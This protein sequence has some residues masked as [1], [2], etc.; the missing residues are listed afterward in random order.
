MHVSIK[1]HFKNWCEGKC[2]Q[3]ENKSAP[4]HVRLQTTAKLA[5]K[6]FTRCARQASM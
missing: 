4:A 3:V 5:K 1:T 2:L 6:D